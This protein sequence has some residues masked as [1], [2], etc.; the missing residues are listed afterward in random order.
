M[1]PLPQQERDALDAVARYNFLEKCKHMG[2]I[3]QDIFDKLVAQMGAE[4]M[5]RV[6]YYMERLKGHQDDTRNFLDGNK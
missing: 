4:N 2:L 5:D 3:Q 1:S 6:R